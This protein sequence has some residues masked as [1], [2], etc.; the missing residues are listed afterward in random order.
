MKISILKN[1]VF[2]ELIYTVVSIIAMLII[3]KIVSVVVNKEVLIPSPEVT[4]REIIRIVESPA[5]L[6]LFLIHQKGQ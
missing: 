4:L 2:K 5:F 1:N 3:W 6:V